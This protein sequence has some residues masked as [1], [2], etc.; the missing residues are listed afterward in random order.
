MVKWDAIVR[1]EGREGLESS[2]C[3]VDTERP[4]SRRTQPEMV[5]TVTGDER[6]RFFF[7]FTIRA[8]AGSA[9]TAG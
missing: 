1:K 3:E 4:K 7:F 6:W 9:E 5:E 2:C 8:S